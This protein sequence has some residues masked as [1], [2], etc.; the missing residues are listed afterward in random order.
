MLSRFSAGTSSHTERR[1]CQRVSCVCFSRLFKLRACEGSN[2]TRSFGVLRGQVNIACSGFTSTAAIVAV[3]CFMFC[4]KNCLL[5]SSLQELLTCTIS[6]FF[7][8]QEA[9]IPGKADAEVGWT[10]QLRSDQ[11]RSD[12]VKSRRL[13]RHKSHHTG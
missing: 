12:H 3:R 4:F 6:M 1:L 7:S 8:V 9:G 10:H 5:A 2:Q 13:T 11:I